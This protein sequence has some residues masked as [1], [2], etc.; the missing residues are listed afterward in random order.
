MYNYE[1]KRTNMS[2]FVTSGMFFVSPTFFADVL[3]KYILDKLVHS[4]GLPFK[5]TDGPCR[6]Y[7]E[8]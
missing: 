5:V 7:R 6:R 1:Y 8:R 3:D 2:C 4:S